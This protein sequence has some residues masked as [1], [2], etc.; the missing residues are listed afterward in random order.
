MDLLPP[1]SHEGIQQLYVLDWLLKN[2]NETL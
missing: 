2:K 1:V